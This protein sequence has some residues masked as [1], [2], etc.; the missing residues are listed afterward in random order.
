[1]TVRWT[2][3]AIAQITSVYEYIAQHS[4]RY[5]Q[6]MVDRITARSIQLA[7]F[8]KSGSTLPEFESEGIRQVIEGNYRLVYRIIGNEVRV[9]AVVHA[10]QQSVIDVDATE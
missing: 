7:T 3:T 4:P 5:A 2:K 1:M 9:L 10:A 6:R 8:P